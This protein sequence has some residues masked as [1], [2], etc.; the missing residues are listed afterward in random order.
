MSMRDYI[1]ITGGA[2]FIGSNLAHAF[3]REGRKVVVVDTLARSGV[4]NNLDWLVREYGDLVRFE[5]L[6]VQ[7]EKR[8]SPLVRGASE[9][10]HLAAQVAVTTSLVNPRADL[11]T[12][13]A[14]TF[15]I[16]EAARKMDQAP[17]ILFTSTNKVYGG[18]SH[19]AVSN[20]S[21]RYG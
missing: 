2:G 13:L 21:S 10:Y 9:V 16:L 14:G 1:L 18:L 15:N 11:E 8:I 5:S 3:L 20:Q 6:P 7:D 12:N 19:I 17:P 4:E